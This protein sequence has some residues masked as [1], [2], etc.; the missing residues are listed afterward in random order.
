MAEHN[1]QPS[2]TI[3]IKALNEAARIAASVESALTAVE[4]YSG[5]VILAD[6][7]STDETVAI[8]S[9][10]PITIVQLENW[11]EKRCGIGP[12]LGYQF[13]EGDFVYVLDGDM[14]LD[15][16]FL[17]KALEAFSAN[18]KLAGVAGLVDEHSEGSLQFRGRKSRN[19]EGTAGPANWLDM[20]GLY[21]RAA[22]EQIGYLSNRNLFACEEQELGL[23]L[24]EA[25]WQLERLAVKSID[26]Y[27]HTEPT[28]T[29]LRK[30][31]K[32]GY[33]YGAGQVLRASLGKPWFPRVARVHKHLLATAILWMLLV[34]GLITAPISSGLLKVWA[35]CLVLLSVQRTIRHRSVKDAA[36]SMIVWHVNAL[37]MIKGFFLA[38]TDPCSAIAAREL[39]RP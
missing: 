5:A 26:H 22:I 31:W 10:Y 23:R 34:L 19:L 17:G 39:H 36:L 29:L 13:S 2:V 30:R 38:Q 3:V 18:E 8:A 37:A 27:G 20:G 33:L 4:G 11:S 7:G 15:P 12:Q 14:E 1:H 24:S 32:S 16:S 6:S 35:A 28:L 25:G 9:R 21:R